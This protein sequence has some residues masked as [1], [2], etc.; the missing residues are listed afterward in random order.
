MSNGWQQRLQLAGWLIF[1]GLMITKGYHVTYLAELQSKVLVAGSALLVLAFLIDW[2]QK[3]PGWSFSPRLW[4]ESAGHFLP[5][6][7]FLIM[8]TTSL[9]LSGSGLGG[10]NIRVLLPDTQTRS[11]DPATLKPGEYLTTTLVDI[12]TVEGLDQDAPVE[13]VGRIHLM[14]KEETQQ[15]FPNRKPAPN[16]MFYRYAIACCAADASPVATVLEG[17]DLT[18]YN[19]GD[20]LHVKGRTSFFDNP[21]G[22]R[23]IVLHAELM[24]KIEKPIKPYLSWL[25]TL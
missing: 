1:F 15:H 4:L 5:L 24:E 21:N 2:P 22:T 23:M 3:T 18:G 19:S 12:Y 17:A 7:I 11:F 13:M 20:W 10:A 9:T 8:G 25:Q 6:L 14:S 16:A